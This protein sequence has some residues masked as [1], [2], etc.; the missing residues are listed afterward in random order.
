MLE[1][2]F[3]DFFSLS[4]VDFLRMYYWWAKFEGSFCKMQT[5]DELDRHDSHHMEVL[6]TNRFVRFSKSG[7][8][9]IL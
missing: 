9:S 1:V 3:A 7:G 8:Y 6:L 2:M 5:D 4:S